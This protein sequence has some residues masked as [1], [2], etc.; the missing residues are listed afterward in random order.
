MK[1]YLISMLYL[2]ILGCL[3]SCG[4]GGDSSNACGS[5]NARVYGG[6]SCDQ[7]ARSPV[8]L[9]QALGSDGRVYGSCTAGLVTLDDYVTSAHCLLTPYVAA[10]KFGVSIVAMVASV[11]GTQGEVIYSSNFKMHPLYNGAAGSRYDIA[12]GTLSK[13]PNPPIGPLPVL[14]SEPTIP[15][16][17]ITAFGYGTNNDGQVGELK[18]ADFK[19]ST[20]ENGNLV[21]RGDGKSSICPGDSGGPAIYISSQGI[22]TIAG[23]NSF[24]NPDES[25]NICVSNAA[26]DFGFVDLQYPDIIEFLVTYAPDI[27]AG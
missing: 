19:I 16:S 25:G 21:V 14:I 6:E 17:K 23:V 2:S 22:S 4:G 8:V 1:K 10:Q 5:L 3:I 13:V 9:L 11:G 7:S 15:G 26:K 24:G 20:L 12:M 18:A 27:A